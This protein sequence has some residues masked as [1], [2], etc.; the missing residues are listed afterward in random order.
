[1]LA[2]QDESIG[3]QI[4]SYGE[5]PAFGTHH[6]FEFLESFFVLDVNGHC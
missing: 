1:M 3:D 4:E 2:N 5:A 6:E